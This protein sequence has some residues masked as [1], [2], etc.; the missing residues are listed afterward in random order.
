VLQGIIN[1][2]K[3][4]AASF[5]D[6][7]LARA[8]VVVP[9]L[10]ASGFATTAA[11]LA[12]T[13]RLGA[14]RAF[15]VLAAGFTAIGVLAGVLVTMRERETAAAEQ[16]SHGE[17]SGL[18]EI[19]E[20][21]SDA[22]TAATHAASRLPLSLISSLIGNPSAAASGA[23][24]AVDRNMPLALLAILVALLLW[25]TEDELA[26]GPDDKDAEPSRDDSSEPTGLPEQDPE[27]LREA[28]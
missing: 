20:M 13:E 21:A 25:Q 9:F 4:A 27:G 10:V 5:V 2:A 6:K 19:G 26:R 18:G 8:S 28:A 22:A 3:S 23:A 15:W 24:R 12:L 1:E 17:D 16:Q 7:Y 14:T 11:A